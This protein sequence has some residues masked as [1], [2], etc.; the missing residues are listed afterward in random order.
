MIILGD[1]FGEKTREK[2]NGSLRRPPGPDFGRFWSDL[3][4]ICGGI[5]VDFCRAF[6]IVRRNHFSEHPGRELG[7]IKPG[8]AIICG[9]PLP[10]TPLGYGDLREAI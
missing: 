1:I 4:A 2:V 7:G 3:G 8:D 5:F 9:S 6:G 10:G